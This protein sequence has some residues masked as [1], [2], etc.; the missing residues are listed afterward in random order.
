ME[1]HFV[2]L[3]KDDSLCGVALI[4]FIDLNNVTTFRE[5]QKKNHLKDYLFKKF[6]SHIL[7]IGNNTLTGQNAYLHTNAITETE[8]L[9]LMQAAMQEVKK[10]YH[11]K[12]ITINLIAVKDFNTEEF[13]DFNGAGFKNYFKFCTQPNMIFNI[14]NDWNSIEDYLL[15]LNT[16]YRT[17][18]KRARKKAEGITKKKLNTTEIQAHQER[19]SELY[20]T[21]ANRA[22]FNTFFLAENHFEVMKKELNDNFLFYGYFIDDILIGFNTL[23]KNNTDMDT[24]FLGYDE[25]VQQ[26]KM[27][28][29]NMLY[30]MIAYAI[31][32]KYK[33]VVF[34]RSAME[35]KSSVGAK[36]E[37]VY[38]VIKHT[39]PIVNPFMG[40]LFNYFEPKVAW[41]ARNP[42]K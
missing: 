37:D 39:N 41:K 10:H 3:F 17:Q 36:A 9:Q 34:A 23:I 21:V 18:Y 28:Y 6:T 35:I 24:Y 1:C 42:F 25:S 40:K 15:A 27:L 22:S 19:I 32:K 26:Q 38:G 12:G 4:Q 33:R 2:G 31:K 16:K 8:A 13:P 29:L 14:S 20:Q 30:D 11:D 5:Q 7:F